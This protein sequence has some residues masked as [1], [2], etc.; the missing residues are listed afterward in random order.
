MRAGAL[1]YRDLLVAWGRYPSRPGPKPG[2][3][4]LSDGA[5]EVVSVGPGVRRVAVGDRVAP[6]FFQRW[7][8]GPPEPDFMGSDLGAGIDGLLAEEVVLDEEGVVKL[9]D[10]LSY[11]EGATLACAG[12]TAW[13]SLM[14]GRQLTPG[15]TVL[16]QGTGGVSIFALQ[17]AKLFGARVIGTTS[18]PQKAARLRDLG[19]DEVID[20]VQNPQ[21]GRLVRDMTGGRGVDRIVEVGGPQ[22]F[23]QSLECAAM[24][25]QIAVVGFVGGVAGQINPVQ[26]MGGHISTLGIGVGSR[27]D[28]VHLLEA[29][30]LAQMRPVI[31][32]IF[33]FD[34]AVGAFRHLEGQRHVGKVVI[35][36]D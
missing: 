7:L 19:A 26:L 36:I 5:G 28:L 6:S 29:M 20:Y 33:P 4:P 15:Q 22:T 32:R 12:V 35:A 23:Q 3:V 17:I 31:D 21:W 11:E 9:P 34:E 25:A 16:V 13:T 30:K 1:N 8:S 14:R 27:A 10:Y 18:S 2:V 24:G